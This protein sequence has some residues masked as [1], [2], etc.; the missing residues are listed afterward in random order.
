MENIMGKRIHDKRIESGMTMEELGDLVGVKRSAVNKR[1]KGQ[2]TNIKRSAIE[3]MA[4]TFDCDPVW[5][6]GLEGTSPVIESNVADIQAQLDR[7]G[8]YYVS[9]K[10][11]ISKVANNIPE[12]VQ[13][14]EYEIELVETYRKLKDKEALLSYA[15]FLQNQEKK[16]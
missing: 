13:L 8:A 12:P 4:K 6:M 7:L 15:R 2:V 1:E 3:K 9:L 14:S 5:L 10:D 16:A 11:V